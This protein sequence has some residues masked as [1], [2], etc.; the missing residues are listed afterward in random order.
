MQKCLPYLAPLALSGCS[1]VL[2]DPKGD[3]GVQVTSLIVTA[4]GLMLIVVIPVI[5]LTLWFAWRYRKANTR[6]TYAPNWSHSS[7]IETVVWLVPLAI[8]AALGVLTWRSS[9]TLDPHKPLASAATTLQ[10]QVVSLDWKWLFIY[11]E[12]GIAT[13]NELVLP[14]DRPV[15]FRVTSGSVM[16]SFMVPALGSQIYA[17][18]GMD[19]DV[20]LVANHEGQYSGRSTNYS[21]AG[22][23]RMTFGTRVTST[24]GFNDW[25]A[26]TQQ[27]AAPGLSFAQGYAAL[28]TPSVGAPVQRFSAVSPTLYQDIINSFRQGTPTMRMPAKAAE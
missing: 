14:K 7:A 2:L 17:M 26:Q 24:Q 18:A 9:H 20:Y 27:Q 5:V 15:H 8:I 12:Q 10:V 22:F 6:A 3:V 28:A 23:A 16:N 13:V 19:N 25:V 21:G 1:S 4:F 11:P